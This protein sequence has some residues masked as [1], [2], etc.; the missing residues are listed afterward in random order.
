MLKIIRAD[1]AIRIKK[2]GYELDSEGNP[3][4]IDSQGHPVKPEYR[5]IIDEDIMCEWQ[6][7]FG[8]E[9][10]Q[11]AAI[12]AKD[13]AKLRL[14][15]IPGVDAECRIIRVEDNAEFEIIGQPDDVM[16][17]HQQLEIEVKRYING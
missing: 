9:L 17:R 15:Y 10:Y 5:D 16:N 1:T 4:T 3:I 7:K 8:N 2:K 13:P 12:N 6:N 11:A 14:W